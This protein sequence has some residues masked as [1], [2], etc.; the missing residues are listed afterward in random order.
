M[1]FQRSP[2]TLRRLRMKVRGVKKTIKKTGQVRFIAIG[3]N[4]L[5]RQKTYLSRFSASVFR[6]RPVLRPP[7]L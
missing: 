5:W 1:F 3:S 2:A 4:W 7:K 6:P